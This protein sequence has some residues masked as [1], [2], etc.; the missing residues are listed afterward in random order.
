ML[1][2]SYHQILRVSVF[3]LLNISVVGSAIIALYNLRDARLFMTLDNHLVS[4]LVHVDIFQVNRDLV[5]VAKYF[6]HLFQR[7]SISL[8]KNEEQHR[9]TDARHDNKHLKAWVSNIFPGPVVTEEG[10]GDL[11]R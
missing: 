9:H 5:I 2:H 4:I 11:T 6:C 7:N 8:G 10:F 1:H 3:W